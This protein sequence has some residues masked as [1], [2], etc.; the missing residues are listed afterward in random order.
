MQRFLMVCCLLFGVVLAARAE[1]PQ[2]LCLQSQSTLA[3]AECLN[4]KSQKE[5]K[6]LSD[7]IAT[8]QRRIDKENSG[9]PQIAASQEAWIKY[10]DA[11]CGDVYAYEERGSYRYRA[12]IECRIEATR[13]RTHAIWSAY[14]RMFGTDVPALPEPNWYEKKKSG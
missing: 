13:S 3:E 8:A 6:I 4:Q 9:K 12:E 14:I 5:D 11:Q 1:K 10:R 7:Y 2:L